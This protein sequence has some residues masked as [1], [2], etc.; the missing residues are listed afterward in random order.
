MA[1]QHEGKAGSIKGESCLTIK[2]RLFDLLSY[3]L[4]CPIPKSG[5][6][7]NIHSEIDI[8]WHT[9]T[10]THTHFFFFLRKEANFYN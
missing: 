3:N 8:G 10:H 2:V 4:L 7:S 5:V 9:Y 6:E 1:E